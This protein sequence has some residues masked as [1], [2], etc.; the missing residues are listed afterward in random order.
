MKPYLRFLKLF[1]GFFLILAAAFFLW[2]S[3]VSEEILNPGRVVDI[4][5]RPGFICIFLAA[6]GLAILWQDWRPKS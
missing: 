2:A 3:Y 4:G 5:D 1:V 6:L